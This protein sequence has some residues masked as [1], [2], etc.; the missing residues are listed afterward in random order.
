MDKS[1][2]DSALQSAKDAGIQNILALRGDAPRGDEYWAPYDGSFVHAID[3]V[4]YIR[5]KHGDYFCIGVAGYP[6]GHNENPDKEQDF[7]YFKEKV[8]AGADFVVTQLFFNSQMFLA[9]HKKCRD[10][11]ITVPI[12]PG[13][14]PIQGYQ[15][16][17]RLVFLTKVGVP[18]SLTKELEPIKNDDKAVKNFGV[19]YA[20]NMIRELL[21]AGIP[22]IHIS[23]LNLEATA[24]RVLLELG[25]AKETMTRPIV[26]DRADLDKTGTLLSSAAMSIEAGMTVSVA[27]AADKS[28][29][30]VVSGAKG[31]P[32]DGTWDEFPN[33]RWGDARSPAF[34]QI[35][36]YG[37][38]IKQTPAEALKLW[39]SPRTR[40][41]VTTSFIKYISGELRALPW[42]DEPMYPESQGIIDKLTRINEAGYWTLAS[43]PAIDGI[44]SDD[45]VYG[46]G[47]HGG[48]V[49]QKA[50]VE[51]F[52]SPAQF[53]TFLS[54]V[55]S[56]SPKVTYYVANNKGDF[57]TNSLET[58]G[59]KDSTTTAL[60]WGV[61]P[62]QPVVQSTMIDKM[63]FLAWRDEAFQIWREWSELFPRASK[64]HEF[65]QKIS[66]T[67]WLVNVI[68]ND[69]KDPEFI[70][71]LFC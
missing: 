44:P 49:Y 50:F 45:S 3:L 43:Q 58:N 18:D 66:N 22:G 36:G 8:E 17:R 61:F 31:L 57:L 10:A 46:W 9:W 42:S 41:D 28:R 39:G 38:S 48:Y 33:G 71:T 59:E 52:V 37:V 26:L 68:C 32:F 62:G 47:P 35:D 40:Q 51:C 16:F 60:T 19:K 11:G 5:Q 65:L 69:Y 63:N 56:T 30:M 54:R 20:V 29:T 4:R 34:G 24:R 7:E 53:P 14:L 67:Y 13:I 55:Q 15:S 70:Y 25:L 6:E 21:D 2:I 23:T 1:M 27:S 12:I 64:E